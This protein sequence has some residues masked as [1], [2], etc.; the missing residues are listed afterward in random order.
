[1]RLRRIEARNDERQEAAE[2]GEVGDGAGDEVLD[3]AREPGA[4]PRPDPEV[5]DERAVRRE[6]GCGDGLEALAW[7]TRQG[8][9][10]SRAAVR[11]KIE[12]FSGDFEG[13]RGADATPAYR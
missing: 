1:M 9:E 6:V 3:P 12:R 13:T 2:R 8:I 5:H 4:R 11:A 7:H 10:P